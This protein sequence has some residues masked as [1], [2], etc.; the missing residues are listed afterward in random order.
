MKFNINKFFAAL[1][2]AASMFVYIDSKRPAAYGEG[3]PLTE[4]E[5]AKLQAAGGM[6][7][8]S[9]AFKIGAESQAKAT[10]PTIGTGTERAR[11]RSGRH[12]TKKGCDSSVAVKG[13]VS[14]RTGVNRV[15]VCR[16][17]HCKKGTISKQSATAT[18]KPTTS[19]TGRGRYRHRRGYPRYGSMKR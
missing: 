1:L 4:T 12:C 5:S 11:V 19:R 15:I 13:R 7:S 17:T 16:G 9:E 2:L 8:P 14:H 3:G 10:Q 18:A 6:Y